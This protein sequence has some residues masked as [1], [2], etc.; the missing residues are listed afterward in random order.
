MKSSDWAESRVVF[1]GGLNILVQGLTYR[2]T[3]V[4]KTGIS[5]QRLNVKR[6]IRKEWKGVYRGCYNQCLWNGGEIGE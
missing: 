1:Q 4:F 2:V 5:T 6:F 3:I